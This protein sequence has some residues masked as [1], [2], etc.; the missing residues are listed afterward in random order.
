MIVAA[1]TFV[2]R[3]KHIK[4]AAI[5]QKSRCL[6]L[7]ISPHPFKQE[8]SLISIP[9][10]SAYTVCGTNFYMR[11]LRKVFGGIFLGRFLNLA[12]RTFQSHERN[13]VSAQHVI[14]DVDL[15]E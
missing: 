10:R 13:W 5:K 1:L 15:K 2:I 4:L 7:V 14:I 8:T 9:L 3:G 11:F 12:T 6:R